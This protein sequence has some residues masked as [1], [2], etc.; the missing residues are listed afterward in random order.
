MTCLSLCIWGAGKKLRRAWIGNS[1]GRLEFGRE[2]K[3]A[4][5][6]GVAE[7]WLP[8][9]RFKPAWVMKTQGGLTSRL[10]LACSSA[11]GLFMGG[12]QMALF[13]RLGGGEGRFGHPSSEWSFLWGWKG[14]LIIFIFFLRG[15]GNES[16]NLIG[17]LPGQYFPISAHGPR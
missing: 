11:T 4:D 13:L 14:P 2:S 3:A 7:T 10:A 5:L 9:F 17:S 16:C 6:G 12:L 15:H 1:N 8:G